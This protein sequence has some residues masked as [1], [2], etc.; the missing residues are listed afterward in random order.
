MKKTQLD[1][2]QLT[3][4]A[5]QTDS[6]VV[7]QLEDA[8]QSAS[9]EQPQQLETTVSPY[10]VLLDI[11]LSA[12][13]LTLQ[14]LQFDSPSQHQFAKRFVQ[15]IE[16]MDT[17]REFLNK[18]KV[19]F[20]EALGQ[21]ERI[22]PVPIPTVFAP[23]I[24]SHVPANKTLATLDDLSVVP[25]QPKITIKLANAKANEAYSH[26]L[27]VESKPVL[28]LSITNVYTTSALNGMVFDFATQT[29][30][31][32]PKTAGEFK[33]LVELRDSDGKEYQSSVTLLVNHDPRSLWSVKE[34]DPT[35]PYQKPHMSHQQLEKANFRMIAASRRGRSH[36]HSGTFRDDD[37]YMA[38]DDASGFGIM[39]T[40]DGAGSAKFSRKGAKIA[41]ETCGT[42]LLQQAT[43]WE[44]QAHLIRQWSNLKIEAKNSIHTHFYYAFHHAAKMAVQQIEQEAQQVK[45][46]VRDFATT[47]LA[48]VFYHHAGQLFV[49]SCWIGDGAI[50]VYG[51]RGKVRLMGSP[52]SGEYAGQTR[53]LDANIL[54]STDFG[55]RIG[56]GCFDDALA[57]LLMTDGVSDTYF[58]TEHQLQRSEGWDGLWDSLAPVRAK[59]TSAEA[60]C[61]WL[62]F[63]VAGH[64]DDRTIAMLWTEPSMTIPLLPPTELAQRLE[65]AE[66]DGMPAAE[67]KTIPS[68][69]SGTN[70]DVSVL[71]NSSITAIV[72]Q[73]KPH[74]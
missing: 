62:H 48:T 47:L 23:T 16:V 28:S 29:L 40:T 31:G 65:F 37:Y 21:I 5:A 63:F 52:D 18:I 39:V 14:I 3:P 69:S 49:A 42:Y 20:Q 72:T 57:L 2:E 53:F 59:T 30:S 61:D 9:T 27:T 1:T 51:P 55:K 19:K 60:L 54:T 26:I 8:L 36:E 41:A 70:S 22:T 12:T 15:Q 34:P 73:E 33:I 58:E 4:Y 25:A 6:L 46:M 24:Q 67:V 71:E 56:V 74:D 44:P 13:D 17:M 10:T 38:Y 66:N 7:E 45:A 50:A 32:T 68:T 35:A 43:Q 64:H 11:N